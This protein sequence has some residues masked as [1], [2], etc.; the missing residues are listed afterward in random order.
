MFL[1]ISMFLYWISQVKHLYKSDTSILRQLGLAT[2]TDAEE[3]HQ[4]DS[5]EYSPDRHFVPIHTAKE[6][7]VPSPTAILNGEENPLSTDLG[8][9]D[10]VKNLTNRSSSYQL[11][12]EEEQEE[13]SHD[14]SFVPSFRVQKDCEKCAQTGESPIIPKTS[15]KSSEIPE[16]SREEEQEE[17][18]AQ[19][20][21]LA[22]RLLTDVGNVLEMEM[23]QEDL[24]NVK[25]DMDTSLMMQEASSDYESM[26]Q[27]TSVEEY[28]SN[29]DVAHLWNDSTLM[30]KSCNGGSKVVQNI[31][32][33]SNVTTP[34]DKTGGGA[35]SIWDEVPSFGISHLWQETSPPKEEGKSRE[36]KVNRLVCFSV[37]VLYVGL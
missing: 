34:T 8:E 22:E 16:A 14:L 35:S 20:K 11:Y 24:L 2:G 33:D 31:W 29:V 10:I 9:E 12:L 13:G 37:S 6:C 18:A 21:A 17:E 7:I 26:V 5:I 25:K 23:C 36:Q 28:Q 4:Q 32:E 3:T 15:G 30:D 1:N 19:E 27:D